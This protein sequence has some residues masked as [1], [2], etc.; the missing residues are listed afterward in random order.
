M[1]SLYIFK[2]ELGL[3]LKAAG[4]KWTRFPTLNKILKG[5]RR[6]EMTILTG[7]SGSGKTTFMS[8]YSL[9][10]AMQGVSFICDYSYIFYLSTHIYQIISFSL[11]VKLELVLWN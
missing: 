9:D 5:H 4:V 8:E 3:C 2:P 7:P 11:F 6:G 1:Y 10:L